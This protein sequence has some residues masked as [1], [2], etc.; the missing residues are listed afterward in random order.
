[1]QA[2]VGGSQGNKKIEV[3]LGKIEGRPPKEKNFAGLKLGAASRARGAL[4][5]CIIVAD[6]QPGHAGI[7]RQRMSCSDSGI[8]TPLYCISSETTSP[9]VLLVGRKLTEIGLVA[10]VAGE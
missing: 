10:P 5:F 3:L 6:F 4:Q 1:M 2:G 8:R 7:V 9:S